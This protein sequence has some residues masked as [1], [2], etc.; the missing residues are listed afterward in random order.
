MTV[1]D[2]LDSEVTSLNINIISTGIEPASAGFGPVAL[3]LKLQSYQYDM[4]PI[5]DEQRD[6]FLFTHLM[7]LYLF[8]IKKNR[9]P[10]LFYLRT[11]NQ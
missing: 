1:I 11:T 8:R 9:D 2:I 5:S 3:P 4:V 10:T 6:K 7:Y